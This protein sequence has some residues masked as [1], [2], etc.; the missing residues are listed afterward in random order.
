MQPFW[1]QPKGP[2]WASTSLRQR[3]KPDACRAVSKQGKHLMILL[4]YTFPAC[5]NSRIV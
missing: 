2:L 1:A 3:P 5:N 4:P